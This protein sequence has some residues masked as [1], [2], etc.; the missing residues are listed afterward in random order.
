MDEEKLFFLKPG[1]DLHNGKQVRNVRVFIQLSFDTFV[2]FYIA[3]LDYR[4]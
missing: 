3:K 4:K 2:F 1:N